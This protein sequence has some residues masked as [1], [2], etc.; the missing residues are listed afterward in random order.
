[1][2]RAYIGNNHRNIVEHN[3]IA[4]FHAA[5]ELFWCFSIRNKQEDQSKDFFAPS[6][7]NADFSDSWLA[8]SITGLGVWLTISNQYSRVKKPSFFSVRNAIVAGLY[9]TNAGPKARWE[10]SCCER[11]VPK[12]VFSSPESWYIAQSAQITWQMWLAFN[13]SS[14]DP[15]LEP[16]PFNKCR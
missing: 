7:L 15:S 4:E 3:S 2:T 16:M 9:F 8:R 13:S 1:M 6:R 12:E 11:L 10:K 5:R 14:A